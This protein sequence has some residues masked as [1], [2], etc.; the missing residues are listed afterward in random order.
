MGEGGKFRFGV[1]MGIGV[2]SGKGI[3]K[4]IALSGGLGVGIDK[5]IW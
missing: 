2:D 4:K 5:N 1:R 3:S